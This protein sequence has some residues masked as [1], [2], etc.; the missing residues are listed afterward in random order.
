M[1]K[2]FYVVFAAIVVA[3]SACGGTHAAPLNS[4]FTGNPAT[5]LGNIEDAIAFDKITGGVKVTYERLVV[6]GSGIASIA[7]VDVAYTDTNGTMYSNMVTQAATNGF[8]KVGVTTRYLSAKNAPSI[9]CVSS[10]FSRFNFVSGGQNVN[11]SCAM[12][13]AVKAVSN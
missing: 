4:I 1:K 6:D 12:F 11:D 3:L 9:D 13:Q 7:A 10:T 5:T 8:F 2:A